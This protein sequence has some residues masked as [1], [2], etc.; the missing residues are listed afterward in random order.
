MARFAVRLHV[1][2]LSARRGKRNAVVRRLSLVDPTTILHLPLPQ[3]KYA[4][5]SNVRRSRFY[6]WL[7]L[8]K[9][10]RDL[11]RMTF[12]QSTTG[13]TFP[14]VGFRV[15]SRR[16][17][18]QTF[19]RCYVSSRVNPLATQLLLF[20]SMREATPNGRPYSR[21]PAVRTFACNLLKSATGIDAFRRHKPRPGRL[22]DFFEV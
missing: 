5:R 4:P 21:R 9:E 14:Q 19:R 13:R 2:S 20:I 15:A 8:T 16:L 18:L 17:I 3:D 6:N 12:D 1:S 11:R 10:A 22:F 7:P